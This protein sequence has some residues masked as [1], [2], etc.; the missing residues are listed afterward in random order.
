MASE[1][2]E[3]RTNARVVIIAL[4]ALKRAGENDCVNLFN[5]KIVNSEK[6]LY[7]KLINVLAIKFV[8]KF[9]GKKW[10]GAWVSLELNPAIK[11]T[12]T[13]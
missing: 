4:D 10:R 3:R 2:Q 7:L 11:C 13:S 8:T 1:R 6:D 12:I 5:K 9:N